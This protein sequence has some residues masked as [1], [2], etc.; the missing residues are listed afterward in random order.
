MILDFNSN[1]SFC[2]KG[3]EKQT[4][5]LPHDA[6][7]TEKRSKTCLNGDKTGYF[8]G[9]IYFYEKVFFLKK[10]DIGKYIAI[11]F[12][13]IYQRATVLINEKEVVYHAYGYTEFTALYI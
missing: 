5:N 1:W 9:G 7:I 3:K 10:E 8:P 11:L 6:M 4:V 12:E 2:K 13:G